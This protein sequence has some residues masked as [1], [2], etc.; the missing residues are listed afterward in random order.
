MARQKCSGGGHELADTLYAN[1]TMAEIKRYERGREEQPEECRSC[2]AV[3]KPVLVK[4]SLGGR[5]S[6]C[7]QWSLIFPYH[8]RVDR[9]EGGA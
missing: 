7:W 4:R 9:K 6:G 5:G 1:F 2:G 3:R 8:S